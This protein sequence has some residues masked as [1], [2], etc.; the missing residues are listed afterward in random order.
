V[1]DAEDLH[2]KQRKYNPNGSSGHVRQGK[3]KAKHF[4]SAPHGHK[5][6]ATAE[7]LHI[8]HSLVVSLHVDEVNE[9]SLSEEPDGLAHRS[10][11]SVQSKSISVEYS[12]S[13]VSVVVRDV[14][15]GVILSNSNTAELPEVSMPQ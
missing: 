15:V 9:H 3:H 6:N 10:N 11:V 5:E 1:V 13:H 7:D 2:S 12:L 14:A 4:C 8:H